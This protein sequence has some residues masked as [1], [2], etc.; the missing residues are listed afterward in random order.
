MGAVCEPASLPCTS[1]HLGAHVPASAAPPPDRE[2]LRE[3]V[4][5]IG[6]LQRQLALAQA[7]AAQAAA[8]GSCAESLEAIEVADSDLPAAEDMDV[9]TGPEAVAA[10]TSGAQPAA[11]DSRKLGQPTAEQRCSKLESQIAAL[12]QQLA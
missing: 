9:E 8:F 4:R 2:R 5:P 12:Q 3:Q 1:G 6:S 10:A 7:A 11:V